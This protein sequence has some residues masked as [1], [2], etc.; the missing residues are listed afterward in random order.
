MLSHLLK[1]AAV[2]IPLQHAKPCD[3]RHD[4]HHDNQHDQDLVPALVADP[5]MRGMAVVAEFGFADFTG[6][7]VGMAGVLVAT[8]HDAKVHCEMVKMCRI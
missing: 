6:R 5:E 7:S 1:A 3:I 8:R 4:D 2:Y